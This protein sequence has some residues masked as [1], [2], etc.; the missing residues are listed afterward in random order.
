MAFRERKS[1]SVDLR[2]R[3]SQHRASWTEWDQEVQ[4]LCQDY[5]Y[6][7]ALRERMER[8]V[9]EF[10]VSR[11]ERERVQKELESMVTDEE[12]ESAIAEVMDRGREAEEVQEVE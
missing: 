7:V 1:K 8:S 11:D 4:Q 9:R 12:I 6:F 3:R 10:K 2:T 5:D